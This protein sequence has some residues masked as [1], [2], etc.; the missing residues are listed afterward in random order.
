MIQRL[1]SSCLQYTVFMQNWASYFEKAMSTLLFHKASPHS[2]PIRA[3]FP[4]FSCFLLV[5]CFVVSSG[6]GE[7]LGVIGRP[8]SHFLHFLVLRRNPPA[9]L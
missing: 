9:L 3:C 1:L 7:E 5:E 4:P 6:V 8:V 2:R